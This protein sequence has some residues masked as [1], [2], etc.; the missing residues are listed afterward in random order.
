MSMSK[1]RTAI[2]Q[3]GMGREM[4]GTHV[5]KGTANSEIKNYT[6]SPEELAAF[7]AS[8]PAKQKEHTVKNS[9]A[10]IW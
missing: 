7:R 4:E 9:T 5:V 10:K 8:L 6:L 1:M 3:F 2:A